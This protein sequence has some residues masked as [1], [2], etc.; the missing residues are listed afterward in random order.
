MR[1]QV[2]SRKA[3]A[4][5]IHDKPSTQQKLFCFKNVKAFLK[6]NEETNLMLC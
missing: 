1:E 3:S 4:F 2:H 6:R 5:R